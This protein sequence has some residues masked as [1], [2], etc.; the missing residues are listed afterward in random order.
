[1]IKAN[2]HVRSAFGL[3]LSAVMLLSLIGGTAFAED[4]TGVKAAGL[5]IAVDTFYCVTENGLEICPDNYAGEG[6]SYLLLSSSGV[7]TLHNFNLNSATAVNGQDD[8]F[9]G[10]YIPGSYSRLQISVEGNCSIVFDSYAAV[11]GEDGSVYGCS[12]YGLKAPETDLYFCG[13]GSLTVTSCGMNGYGSAESIA[14]SARSITVDG[15]VSLNAAGGGVDN[16]QSR[17]INAGSVALA[18]PSASVTADAGMYAFSCWP[19]SAVDGYQLFVYSDWNSGLTGAGSAAVY[20]VEAVSVE[21]PAEESAEDNGNSDTEGLRESYPEE[22]QENTE[23]NQ[24]EVY[25]ENYEEQDINTSSE[26][27]GEDTGTVPTEAETI[28]E[29]I[30][31]AEPTP[32]SRISAVM[33]ELS[34]FYISGCTT[35]DNNDGYIVFPEGYSY[36]WCKEGDMEYTAVEVNGISYLT[37]GVYLVRLAET[38]EYLA[39]EPYYLE[40]P[41]YT[42]PAAEN[43]T[44]SATEPTTEPTAEPTTE[45]TTEPAPQFMPELKADFSMPVFYA[46]SEEPIKIDGNITV[47]SGEAPKAA[48]LTTPETDPEG[49]PRE[50]IP[51]DITFQAVND[52]T[53]KLVGSGLHEGLEYRLGTLAGD[54]LP[55][56]VKDGQ[57]TITGLGNGSMISIITPG[58]GITTQDSL[59][60]DIQVNASETPIESQFTVT[61]CTTLA[62][63]D[64]TLTVPAGNTYEYSA[65]GENKYT[66]IEGSTDASVTVTGLVSGY[67]DIRVRAAGTYLASGCVTLEVKEYTAPEVRPE[68]EVYFNADDGDSGYLYGTDSTMEYKLESDSDWTPVT[69]TSLH[70]TGLSKGLVIEVRYAATTTEVPSAVK[71]IMIDRQ[72]TPSGDFISVTDCTTAANNNGTITLLCDNYTDYEIR[73]GSSGSFTRIEAKNITGLEDGTYYIR[74]RASGTKLAS[75]LCSVIV[76]EYVPAGGIP[77]QAISMLPYEKI[78]DTTDGYSTLTVTFYPANTTNQTVTFTSSNPSVVNFGSQSTTVAGANG[79]ATI[80]MYPVGSGETTITATTSNGMTATCHATVAFEYR[81]TYNKSGTWYYDRGG[82]YTV[83]TNGP[84]SKFTALKI[85]GQVVNPQYYTTRANTDGTTILTISQYAMS[86][87]NHGAYQKLQLC[88]SDGGTATTFLHIM[89]VQDKPI[90]GDDSNAL[91]W[92]SMAGLSVT[93]LT[94]ILLACRKHRLRKNR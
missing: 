29:Q 91:L 11:F 17:G 6:D 85:N 51:S 24:T 41:A 18:S 23:S 54:Y 52:T 64:G 77:C 82:D 31:E 67:Y 20:L 2:R 34:Y 42:P 5:D 40:V 65:H 33:P 94:G 68:P 1:M 93:A 66:L 8:T 84:M 57:A 16:G 21:T 45:P 37:P 46:L 49:L 87:L 30:P 14:I 72:S 61:P 89:S 9:A 71:K 70:F 15:S 47:D 88:Y 78:F 63:N 19:Y 36:E 76:E 38:A 55:L 74:A 81:F 75:K 79:T 62:Q 7:L 92:L 83:Q 69:G 48:D 25:P 86:C 22:Y 12:S 90:T 60:L 13:S 58:D 39:S 4:Y 50:V 59:P 28:I 26:G 10:L 44:E 80:R 35:S 43:T 3:L 32:D 53:G 73:F 27:Y 56:T